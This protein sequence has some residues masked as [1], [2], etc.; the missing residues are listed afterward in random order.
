MTYLLS[1]KSLTESK[2][3][4]KSTLKL[5]DKDRGGLVATSNCYLFAIFLHSFERCG[6]PFKV[7]YLSRAQSPGRRFY[8]FTILTKYQDIH[9]FMHKHHRLGLGE[10][11]SWH[12]LP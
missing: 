2:K 10:T 11:A 12:N 5:F 9:Y 4:E 1:Q 8:T 3:Q 6:I 7:V